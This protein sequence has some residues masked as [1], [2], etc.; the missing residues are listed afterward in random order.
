M[1]GINNAI[2]IIL[3]LCV[4]QSGSAQNDTSCGTQ[5][6]L[7]GC[8]T[9]ANNVTDRVVFNVN[10]SLYTCANALNC[11]SVNDNKQCVE[12]G[13][14]FVNLNNSCYAIITN[15]VTYQLNNATNTSQCTAC[16]EPFM[17]PT[18]NCS[19]RAEICQNYN[20]VTRLC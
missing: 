8:L 5:N 14:G 19:I 10:S 11:V 1:Q 15:C 4:F 6:A 18:N 17:D 2:V 20:N 16:N 13:T 12:C 3:L 7:I 9:C